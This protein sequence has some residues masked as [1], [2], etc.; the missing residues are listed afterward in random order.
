MITR[1]RWTN[2]D[3]QVNSNL[4][5]VDAFFLFIRLALIKQIQRCLVT[6]HVT[7]QNEIKIQRRK[8]R[9][10]A[11]HSIIDYTGCPRFDFFS[12]R[13]NHYLTCSEENTTT[14]DFVRGITRSQWVSSKFYKETKKSVWTSRIKLVLCEISIK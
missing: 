10:Y 13:S 8:T 7:K 12:C 11:F 6:R 5:I 1:V 3:D 2:E 14:T 9:E 4:V